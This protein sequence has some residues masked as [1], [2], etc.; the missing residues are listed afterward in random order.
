MLRF[1]LALL[2]LAGSLASAADRLVTIDTRPGVRVGYWMMERPGAAATLLLLPGG[3]GAIGMRN[4]VPTSENFLVRSRDR[5]ASAGFNVAIVGKPSD[6]S[7]LDAGF[8]AG[9]S[10]VEDLRIIV[11]RLRKN[12]G[13]PVWLVGTS[14]GTISAAA[15]AIA[16]DPASI[17]GVV[18]T[19]SVTH[20]TR[21]PPVPALALAEI[22]VPVLV[23][24]HRRDACRSCNPNEVGLIMDALKRAP[25]KKLILVDGGSGASGDPCEA[26]HWHGYIGMEQEA[27]DTIADWIRNPA[28]EKP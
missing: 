17:A 15:A 8:R 13:K 16:L 24:H 14:R 28:P 23:M 11:E 4:G 18:L 19:S 2:A 21:Y 7:E 20:G 9:A 27:V 12:L 25:R 26:L 10:H 22:R 5:F 6:R 1:A 3:D